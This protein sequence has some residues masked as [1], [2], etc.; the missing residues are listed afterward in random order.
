MPAAHLTRSTG[1]RSARLHRSLAALLA[2]PLLCGGA[3]AFLLTRGGDATP[4]ALPAA[5]V[6][7]TTGAVPTATPTMAPATT[8]SPAI[9]PTTTATPLPTTPPTAS[10][11]VVPTPAGGYAA[12]FATWPTGDQGNVRTRFDPAGGE[13]RVA[14]LGR[15]DGRSLYAPGES[16][17]DDFTL[18]VDAR[19]VGGPEE[20]GYGL[21]FR[22]QPRGPNDVTNARYIFY[23]TTNGFYRLYLVNANGTTQDIQPPTPSSAIRRGAAANHLT[24]TCRGNRIT[25]AVNGQ[26][27]GTYNATVTGA[28]EIGIVVAVPDDATRAGPGIDAAFSNLRLTPER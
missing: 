20:D 11:T 10:P 14:L 16:R 13:Y 5:V 24:V 26:T 17:F 18:E 19:R 7:T 28:G 23:V 21:V 3:G 9:T 27:L 15:R 2:A 8:P 4:T 12:N 22:R 6:T 1:R 25:L